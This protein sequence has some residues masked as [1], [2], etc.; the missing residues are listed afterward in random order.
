[1]GQVGR[2]KG[3][4]NKATVDKEA[5]REELRTQVRASLAPM[6]EAQIANAMGIKYLIARV[7]A[8]GKFVKLT[9]AQARLKEGTESDTE[10]IEVWEKDPSVQAFTDLMN[11]TIDMPAKPPEQVNMTVKGSVTLTERVAEARKRL[12]DGK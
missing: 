12:A 6:V 5:L 1:M 11:R 7:K 3:A 8:T 2:P 10:I 4:K 9:E